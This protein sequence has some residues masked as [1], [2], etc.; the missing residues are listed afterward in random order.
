MSD[1]WINRLVVSGPVAGVRAVQTAAA[2]AEGPTETSL[3]FARLLQLLPEDE[4]DEFD[5]SVEPWHD[6]G[7][8]FSDAVEPPEEESRQAPDRLELT[9]RFMLDR[10]DPDPLLIRTSALFRLSASCSDGWRPTSTSRSRGL[11][12]TVT[13]TLTSCPTI[14]RSRSEPRTI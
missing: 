10:Y 13:R 11:S 12:T 14:R 5:E 2:V 4:R 7:V 3:S 8:S 9:Y 1:P 6:T